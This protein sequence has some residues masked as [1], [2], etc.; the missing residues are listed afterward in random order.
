MAPITA[1][2][3]SKTK[4]KAF[5]Y[6]QKNVL[7]TAEAAEIEKENV[8]PTTEDRGSQMDPPPQPLSQR[9]ATKEV[10]DCPQTPLGRL[11]LSELLASGEDTRQHL[12]LTPIERVLWDN[13]PLSSDPL[14]SIPARKG[15]K[16]AHSSSPASS[17]QNEASNHFKRD[18]KANDVQALQQ[19]LKTP[20]A[21]PADDLWSRYSLNPGTI[22]RRSPT[23]PTVVGFAHLMHSSSPQTPASH[24]Q[25]DSGGL[26]RALSCIEWPT[27]A[28]KRRK[29][30]HNSS[31]RNSAAEFS[32]TE[33]HGVERSKMSRVSMLVERIHDG[34]LKPAVPYPNDTSSEVDGSSPAGL[35][36]ASP[37]SPVEDDVSSNRGSQ[38]MM[39]DVAN[40][41]SQTA[42]APQTDISK[43][44]VL[45]DQDIASLDKA[46][47][48]DFDDDDL[49]V[50]M[51]E[52]IDTAINAHRLNSKETH[53]SDR[54][55]KRTD[56]VLA[57]GIKNGG[58]EQDNPRQPNPTTICKADKYSDVSFSTQRSSSSLKQ[59]P[60]VYDEFDE[61]DN[62][63]FAADLE[64]VCAKYDSQAQPNVTQASGV[65]N[66]RNTE[67]IRS[68]T[69][70]ATPHQAAPVVGEVLSD[71][72]DFGGDSDFEQI[73][74]ECAE[75]TQRQ[76]VSQPQSSVCTL[77]SGSR[78]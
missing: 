71:D 1:S 20:K 16:R 6:E 58:Q 56:A 3:Q 23:A 43:P 74:A 47:S 63:V 10:R 59:A 49:D 77:N 73:A 37:S 64:D 75:A 2:S 18:K 4:L 9:S 7:P 34:L 8:Q 11:P 21:D 22:E 61:D 51:M 30:F 12:N 33:G 15:R 76:Q 25:K 14:R 13:S 35:K 31:Q 66:A 67:R 45:S 78:K 69:R 36:D 62:D 50:E 42:M 39:D 29:L 40:V 57:P 70:A 26:R 46:D 17:S 65:Q 60:Q 24:I 19:T 28:A 68:T 55:A 5:Q 41:L 27:S 38:G 72:D 53:R 44:L 54:E 52:S 32:N 48:S